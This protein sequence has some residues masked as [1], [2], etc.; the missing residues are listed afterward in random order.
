[1]STDGERERTRTRLWVPMMVPPW[2][3]CSWNPAAA[4]DTKSL[5][6]TEADSESPYPLNKTAVGVVR[7][8]D[9]GAAKGGRARDP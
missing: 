2:R 6:V 4:L 5:L 1:M 8:T 9:S 3:S 7:V